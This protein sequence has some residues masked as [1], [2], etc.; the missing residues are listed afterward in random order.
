MHDFLTMDCFGMYKTKQRTEVRSE[1]MC[2]R[3][4]IKFLE[5]QVHFYSLYQ[6]NNLLWWGCTTNGITTAATTIFII[7]VS[8]AIWHRTPLRS[9]AHQT[10]VRSEKLN[11]PPFTHRKKKSGRIV[12]PLFFFVLLPLNVPLLH[13]HRT[14][15]YTI[16]TVRPFLF[17]NVNRFW[18]EVG[19]K[20]LETSLDTGVV[21]WLDSSS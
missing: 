9:I 19:G 10:V 12:R 11:N 3:G 18:R 7:C 8:S 17:R 14:L 13:T 21:P 5:I 2:Q 16:H 1:N 4:P 15:F 6:N 20:I